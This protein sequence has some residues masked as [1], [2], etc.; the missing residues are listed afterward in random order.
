MNCHIQGEYEG[1]PLSVQEKR[2]ERN[3]GI[4]SENW[5]NCSRVYDCKRQHLE[6]L[7]LLQD[8]SGRTRLILDAGC[9]PGTYGIVLAEQQGVE[10]VGVDISTAAVKKAGDRAA[11]RGCFHAIEGDLES[12]PFGDASFDIVFSGWVLHHFPSLESVCSELFRVLRPGGRIAVVEPNEANL[13]MRVSRFVEY[14]LSP[15]I[16]RIRWDTPNRTVHSHKEYLEVLRKG[17]FSDLKYSSC[18]A[19]LPADLSFGNPAANVILGLMFNIRALMLGLGTRLL[20]SPLN[21]PDLLIWGAK[22][23]IRSE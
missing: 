14:V 9:G 3:E 20:P 11:E 7:G 19:S 6:L 18:H 17:G 13:A 15:I 10:V 21:G 1:K 8:D 22:R 16:A 4:P 2:T 23:G 5:L 12:L